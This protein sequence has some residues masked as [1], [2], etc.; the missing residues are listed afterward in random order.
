MRELDAR[1][2]FNG[3]IVDA[4]LAQDSDTAR[5]RLAAG[6]D[7]IARSEKT[8]NTPG[9]S[10]NPLTQPRPAGAVA[11]EHELARASLHVFRHRPTSRGVV[12]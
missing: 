1:Q 4:A 7:G 5:P 9:K 3:K 12:N 10:G 11:D 6:G 8:Q 2:F